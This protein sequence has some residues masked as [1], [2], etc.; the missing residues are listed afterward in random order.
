M[1]IR[2][3]QKPMLA[4]MPCVAA[5]AFVFG[6]ASANTATPPSAPCPEGYEQ[7]AKWLWLNQPK[8]TVS[9]ADLDALTKVRTHAMEF[10][11]QRIKDK[12][13]SISING[14]AYQI[15]EALGSGDEGVVYRAVD[16]S[17]G[18]VYAIKQ[19]HAKFHPRVVAGFIE[20]TQ[21]AASSAIPS[22]FDPKM[23]YD[24]TTRAIRFR[25]VNGVSMGWVK[26]DLKT[27]NPEL[28]RRLDTAFEEWKARHCV[29][30]VSTCRPYNVVFDF[31]LRQFVLID[32]S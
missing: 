5:I 2:Q 24:L 14:N 7:L 23:P 1:R 30:K 31:D 13:A 3:I 18:H 25:Y 21:D 28:A 32:A 19:Y 8:V 10:A 12:P 11:S 9:S 29:T 17:T 6:A 15:M 22:I 27:T 20:E 26:D 16:P 4:T